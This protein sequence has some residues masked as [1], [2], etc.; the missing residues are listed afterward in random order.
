MYG[1]EQYFCIMVVLKKWLRKRWVYHSI[2]WILLVCFIGY[3]LSHDSVFA[4]LQLQNKI[5][6]LL[7]IS[8]EL[9]VIVYT[10][11][12]FRKKFFRKGQYWK[13]FI[14]LILFIISFYY[15]DE[16]LVQLFFQDIREEIKLLYTEIIFIILLSTMAQ[17]FKKEILEEYQLAQLEQ[18]TTEMELNN[19]KAQINP[20]FLFNNLNNIYAIN[21]IDSEKG[22]EMIL[23]L[24]DVMRYHLQFSKQ[25]KI[26]LS[27]E[28]QLIK[29]YIELE[30]LR[31]NGNCDLQIQIQENELNIQI[32][33]LLLLPFI[34]N[35]F[36][37]GTHPTEKCFVYLGLEANEKQLYF[38]IK[39]SI[40]LN[41]KVV[42]TN[43]GLQNTE[44]RLNLLY[45]HKHSL[46]IKQAENMYVVQLKIEL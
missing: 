35:A 38:E 17:H 42:K 21:Q 30:K 10:N 4:A 16:L 1:D 22:S 32:A 26:S 14:F 37:H 43:I 3:L 13:Y 39:N 40:F 9:L 28:I 23:E 15:F 33:P 25:K 24:S 2:S 34:E 7:H 5:Y 19:L 11:F 31:L 44:K 41:K 46:Q 45:P 18:K 8:S 12:Y 27:D 29:S 6:V 36:K 20:H